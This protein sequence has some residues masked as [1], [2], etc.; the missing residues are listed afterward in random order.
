MNLEEEAELDLILAGADY[1]KGGKEDEEPGP[2]PEQRGKRET[3]NYSQHKKIGI[4][5]STLKK[6]LYKV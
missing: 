2:S 3:A 4:I 6:F 1:V 5:K